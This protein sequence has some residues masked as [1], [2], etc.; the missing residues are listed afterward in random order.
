MKNCDKP[1]PTNDG[2]LRDAPALEFPDWSGMLPHRNRITF[3]QAVRWN[4]EMLTLFPLRKPSAKL[5]AER[6]CHAEFIL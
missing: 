3:E 4:E 1:A 6:R 2:V 5:K